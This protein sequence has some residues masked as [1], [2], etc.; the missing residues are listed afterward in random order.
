MSKTSRL[1]VRLFEYHF[2][3]WWCTWSLGFHAVQG[4]WHSGIVVFGKEYY[5]SKD[6]M[7][8]EAGR[9]GFGRPTKVVHPYQKSCQPNQLVSLSMIR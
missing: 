3:V 9:T 7:F 5:F 6:T 4:I 2:D 1:V 8:D